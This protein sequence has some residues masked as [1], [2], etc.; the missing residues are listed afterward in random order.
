MARVLVFAIVCLSVGHALGG[1]QRASPY[2]MFA[3]MRDTPCASWTEGDVSYQKGFNKDLFTRH[4]PEHAWVYGYL[5]GAGLIP[6]PDRSDPE[7]VRPQNR[8]DVRG[9]DDW[10]GRYCRTHPYGSIADGAAALVAEL[11][12]R[13]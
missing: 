5:A 6:A 13:R 12:A 8:L 11:N 10:M 4:A 1:A 2:N 9:V 7:R 3:D